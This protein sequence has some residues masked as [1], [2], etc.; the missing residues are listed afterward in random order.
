MKR[1][2]PTKDAKRDALIARLRDIALGAIGGYQC[3][4]DHGPEFMGLAYNM[5]LE[6]FG[7][8]WAAVIAEFV[9]EDRRY[10]F[11]PRD[12]NK[13]D[14]LDTLADYLIKNGCGQ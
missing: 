14:R 12:I 9:P 8:F 4:L 2:R 3:D 6:S 13:I 1:K 11:G 5:G 10:A 7:C